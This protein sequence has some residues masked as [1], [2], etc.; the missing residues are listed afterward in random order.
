MHLA[1]QNAIAH[2]AS[3]PRVEEALS[4]IKHASI[5]LLVSFSVTALVWIADS[6]AGLAGADQPTGHMLSVTQVA[7]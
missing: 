7:E 6:Y 1:F 5:W 3:T 4:F 2:A